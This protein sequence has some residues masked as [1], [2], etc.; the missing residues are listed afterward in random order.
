MR[1]LKYFFIICL[2]F[3][4]IKFPALAGIRLS[5]ERFEFEANSKTNFLTGS[6]TVE[7]DD[8]EPV[9]FKVYPQYFEISEN[10][11]ILTDLKEE[12]LL[13]KNIRFNPAE[14]T[15]NRNESQKIRFTITNVKDLPDGESRTALFLEDVKTKEQA[16]PSENRNA[17]AKLVLKTRVAIPIYVDKGK[18]FKSGSIE[19]LEIQKY[20]NNYYYDLAVKSSGNSKIR[21]G[22]V[23]QIIKG[24]DLVNEFAINEHPIQ[25][26]STGKFRDIIPAFNMEAGQK[27]TFKAI[28]SYKN[29]GKEEFITHEI[30]MN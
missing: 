6:F 10:G 20:K 26:G 15:L 3:L 29:Q 27:Y 28:M 14:F 11:T 5:A 19:K 30:P 1:F 23:G 17:S 4:L 8:K 2:M 7:N 13:S 16:L 22:G 12:G 9:R 25:A 21:V 18:V 24:N